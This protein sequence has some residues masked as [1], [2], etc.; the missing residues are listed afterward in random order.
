MFTGAVSVQKGY[1]VRIDPE[2]SSLRKDVI[3]DNEIAVFA[4][5]FLFRVL[6]DVVRFGGKANEGLVGFLF[7]KR[8]RDVRIPFKWKCQG[9]GSFFDFMGVNSLGR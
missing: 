7:A 1:D 2:P 8:L 9:F 5:Q 6:K 3:R 4:Y